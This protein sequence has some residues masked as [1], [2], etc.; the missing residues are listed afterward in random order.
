MCFNPFKI[1]YFSDGAAS[2]YKN[3]K[4]LKNLCCHKS[5]F[6]IDAEW[7]FFATSHGKGP[8]DGLGGTLKR[9]AAKASLQR[10][11]NEQIMTA[12][13]LYFYAQENILGIHF[14]YST[15]DEWSNEMEVLEDRF[16]NSFSVV[17][18]QKLHAFIPVSREELE[19]K[20]VSNL[21]EGRLVRISREKENIEFKDIN[22]F[23]TFVHDRHWWLGCVLKKYPDNGK[24]KVTVL[25][26]EGPSPSF[27][28]PSHPKILLLEV[29][30]ILSSV[31]P[32]TETGRTYKLSKDEMKNASIIY[33]KK[34]SG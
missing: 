18:T 11:Y 17:G 16:R 6:G 8:C 33:E 30:D 10:P 25:R 19:V 21:D 34:I 7:H 2:Q 13:Q 4:N 12:R 29:T 24:V 14:L 32:I 27:C 31:D 28:Y 22:G 26:P 23:I 20:T 1:V 5:D 9:L 3:F 15:M